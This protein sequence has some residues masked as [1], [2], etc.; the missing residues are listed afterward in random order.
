MLCVCEYMCVHSCVWFFVT[1]QAPLSMGFSRQEYWSGLPFPS[2]GGLPRPNDRT[3]ISYI[4][5][6]LFTTEPPTLISSLKVLSPN[7]VTFWGTQGN[8]LNTSFGRQDTAQLITQRY[9][10]LKTLTLKQNK[11]NMI[12]SPSWSSAAVVFT[13]YE[14]G[15]VWHKISTRL[16]IICPSYQI[17]LIPAPRPYPVWYSW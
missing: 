14:V 8:S 3:D 9:D 16:S 15:R 10:K 6:R 17:H 5:G 2:P 13:Q 7:T 11:E 4:A 12:R 1:H